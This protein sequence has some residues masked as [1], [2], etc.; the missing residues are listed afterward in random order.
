MNFNIFKSIRTTGLTAVVAASI[1]IGAPVTLGMEGVKLKP[2]YDSVGV[3]TVCGGETEHVEEREY[4]QKECEDRFGVQYGYYSFATA[5][6]YNAK[7]SEIV[8]PEIHAAFTDMSYN[9]GLATVE[10]STMIREI[11]AGRPATACAAI[12]L[13]NKAGG[14]D[15]RVRSNNCYGVWTR[16]EKIHDLCMKGVR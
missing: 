6:F 2:Y 15:C 1:G 13:Y 5:R 16:R 11:N 7:A 14:R 10:K 3:R 12:L 8:T 9:V 4:T